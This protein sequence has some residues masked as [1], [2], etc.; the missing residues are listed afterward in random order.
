MPHPRRVIVECASAHELVTLS[1][2][3]S[4]YLRNVLRLS[5]GSAVSVVSRVDQLNFDGFISALEPT[6]QVQLRDA[7]ST[8]AAASIVQTIISPLLKGNHSDLVVEKCSELG[9]AN[10]EIF[11]A[12]RSVIK[13]QPRNENSRKSRFEKVALA[14]ARQCGRADIPRINLYSSLKLAL[15][16][17]AVASPLLYCS[18]ESDAKPITALAPFI[19]P[20]SLVIGPEGDFTPGEL[21]LLKEHGGTPITLGALLL[22]S[23]TAAIAAVAMLH[24][25]SPAVLG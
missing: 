2:S 25:H 16:N 24:A 18:L 11:E 12:E 17:H 19:H 14:A 23:E 21:L 5:C 15:N 7:S 3:E 13:L 1:A 22:R 20:L 6:V 8:K 4:H 10:F 9:V